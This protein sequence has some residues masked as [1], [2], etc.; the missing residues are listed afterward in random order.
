LVA[1]SGSNGTPWT[2]V[3]EIG[4]TGTVLADDYMKLTKTDWR[5]VSVDSEELVGEDGAADNA[6]DDNPETI[7]HTQWSDDSPAHPH[8]LV[9]DLGAT[10]SLAGFSMLPRQDGSANGRIIDYEFYIGIYPDQ[11]STPVAE[12]SF[13]DNANE[14]S[15]TF[16]FTA[17]RYIRL[18]ALSGSNGA[19]WTSVA[20][21]GLTGIER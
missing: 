3:A 10:Y 5:L 17:G 11:W 2:S 13:A 8:E 15:V 19:P 9:I 4:V 20:E 7:W 6:F 16:P 21:I 18:V 14:K 12:G 1:L